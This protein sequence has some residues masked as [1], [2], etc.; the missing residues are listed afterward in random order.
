MLFLHAPVAA[1]IIASRLPEGLEP[2][3]YAG[4]AW[5]SLVFFRMEGIRYLGLPSVPGAT[6]FPE[7]NVRTYARHVATGKTGVWFDTLWA[8]NH[9]AV[10]VVQRSFGLPYRYARPMRVLQSATQ[11]L[12]EARSGGASVSAEAQLG[13]RCGT[14]I[15]D[16][17]EHWLV[18]RYRLFAAHRGQIKEGLV[19]HRKYPLRSVRSWSF[20][21]DIVSSVGYPELEYQLAHFSDGVD[22]RLGA[23]TEV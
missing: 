19:E 4:S 9:A 11:A 21:G 8:Q 3:V 15:P 10:I 23:L 18:E 12:Y 5:V 22:V 20:S 7:F 17:L 16:T 13:R 6:A 14:A 2:E 1:E